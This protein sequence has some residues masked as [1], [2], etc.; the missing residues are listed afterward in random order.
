MQQ[1]GLGRHLT[2][3]PLPPDADKADKC[4]AKD[5]ERIRNEHI[6]GIKPQ[7]GLET[8]ESLRFIDGNSHDCGHR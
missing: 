5:P 1:E 8:H 6:I 4:Q 7:L 2:L 3:N